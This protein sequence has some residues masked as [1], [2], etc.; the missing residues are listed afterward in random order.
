[1]DCIT[2]S[3]QTPIPHGIS[4]DIKQTLSKITLTSNMFG[5]ELDSLMQLKKKEKNALWKKD[6]PAQQILNETDF[7]D[8]QI[9]QKSKLV[10]ST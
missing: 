8:K 4:Q 9:N 5:K 2:P 10:A 1:M 7:I 3:N 6:I